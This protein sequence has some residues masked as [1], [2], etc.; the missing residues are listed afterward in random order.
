MSV[1][2]LTGFVI[3][4]GLLCIYIWAL[5]TRV[6]LL[7]SALVE[8]YDILKLSVDFTKVNS[9][10]IRELWR[11]HIPDDKKPTIN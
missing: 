3:L 6:K 5:C 7:E 2:Y 4:I 1:F 11:T 8:M 10:H 9:E